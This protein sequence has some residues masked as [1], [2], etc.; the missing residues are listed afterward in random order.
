[1][2]ALRHLSNIGGYKVSAQKL[3]GYGIH[4]VIYKV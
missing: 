4:L 1:M 3:V 2:Q